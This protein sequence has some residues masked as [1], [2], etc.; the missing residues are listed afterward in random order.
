MSH[1]ETMNLR[2]TPVGRASDATASASVADPQPPY[3][4]QPWAET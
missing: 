4:A 2:Q 3:A 1:V